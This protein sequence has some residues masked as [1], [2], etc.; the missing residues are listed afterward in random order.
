MLK[1]L[2]QAL[3]EAEHP[4]AP[5]GGCLVYGEDPLLYDHLARGLKALAARGRTLESCDCSSLGFADFL[6]STAAPSFFAVNKVVH[7]TKL[8]AW[9]R[10]DQE[11]FV[12]WLKDGAVS[13]P[14]DY[15]FITDRR[16]AGNR[17]PVTALKKVLVC[18][19]SARPRPQEAVAWLQSRLPRLEV[20]AAPGVLRQLVDLH[21]GNLALIERELEKMA[22]YVGSGGVIEMTTV[23]LLGAD[24]GGG[25]IFKFCDYVG[26]GQVVPALQLLARLQGQRFEAVMIVGML[27]RQYRLLGRLN[28]LE[29]QSGGRRPPRELACVLGVRDFA[30]KRLAAQAAGLDAV[31]IARAFAILAAA[32]RTLKRSGLPVDILLEQLVLDLCAL[33]RSAG[34]NGGGR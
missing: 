31:A 30:L 24:S 18:L 26:G 10:A 13:G 32:D 9:P 4:Q 19:K 1:K 23:E 11:R 17:F 20:R 28:E 16:L 27:A 14:I 15:L 7:L 12:A 34:R 8:S 6:V 2:A 29:A 5:F 22:L 33:K 3:K 25:N 21:E